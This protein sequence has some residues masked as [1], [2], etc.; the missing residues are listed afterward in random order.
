MEVNR[1]LVPLD[2]SS[3]STLSLDPAYEIARRFGA[4]VQLLMVVDDGA[5]AVLQKAA[6]SE[7]VSIERAAAAALARAASESPDVS[8]D[9]KVIFDDDPAHTIVKFAQRNPIDVVVMATHGRTGVG[10]W[11]LGSVTTKVLRSSPVPVFVV[12]APKRGAIAAL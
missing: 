6:T 3:L 12:P 8:T 5:A 11:L 10:R 7:N 1:I 2:E 4:T 9:V